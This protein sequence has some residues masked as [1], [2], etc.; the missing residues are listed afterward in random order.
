MTENGIIYAVP[1]TEG[2]GAKL[3]INY[4]LEQYY[5]YMVETLKSGGVVAYRNAV[6]KALGWSGVKML[7]AGKKTLEELVGVVLA[8]KAEKKWL[9][10][11]FKEMGNYKSATYLNAILVA[12]ELPY[13]ILTKQHKELEKRNGKRHECRSGWMLVR[14]DDDGN[15]INEKK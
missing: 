7:N 9:I 6:E 3:E 1:D 11:L 5:I 2:I 13:R 8:T 12:L 14:I 15:V 4:A 10:E